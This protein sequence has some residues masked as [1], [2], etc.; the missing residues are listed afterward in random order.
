MP[1]ILNKIYL[2]NALKMYFNRKN[3]TISAYI[4][5]YGGKN[6]F[7]DFFCFDITHHLF[8]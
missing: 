3:N 5:S 4:N 2:I 6:V 8:F 7:Y 1:Q